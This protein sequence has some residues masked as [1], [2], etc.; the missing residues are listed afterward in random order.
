MTAIT[1]MILAWSSDRLKERGFHL[2]GPMAVVVIGYIISVATLHPYARYFASFLYI[3]GAF[4]AN[5]LVNTWAVSTMGRT[6]EKRAAGLAVIN[7]MGFF[8]NIISPFFFPSTDA[9][10]YLMALLIMMGFAVSTVCFCMLLKYLIVK[11][12]KKLK[13]EADR[14]GTIYNP[15]TT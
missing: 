2:L 11:D 6:T 5:P 13:E 1:S 10:R 7:V 14:N 12:N 3:G 8:G 4:S 15:F 9:P